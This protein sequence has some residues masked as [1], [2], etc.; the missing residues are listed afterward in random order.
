MLIAGSKDTQASDKTFYG[1]SPFIKL[2]LEL[3]PLMYSVLLGYKVNL[4]RVILWRKSK[5]T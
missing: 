3:A 4:I 1:D 5:L 2:F